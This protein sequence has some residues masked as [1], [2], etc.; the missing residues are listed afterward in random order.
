MSI[1]SILRKY[2]GYDIIEL[3]SRGN[4][5]IFAALYVARKLALDKKNVLIPDQ[6]GWFTYK[7][8]PKKLGLE[9]IEVKTDLGLLDPKDLA[10][11]DANCLLYENPAG[12]YANQ[13]IEKIYNACKCTVILDVSGS[14]GDP[15]LCNG[16]YADIIVGSFGKWKVATAEYGGFVAIKD[17]ETYDIAKEIFN[18]TEFDEA[19]TDDV[20]KALQQVPDRLKF[21]YDEC[22]TIKKDL[23]GM[24]IVYPDKKGI[25]VI[26]RYTTE[27]DKNKILDYCERHKYQWTQCPRYIK[28]MENAISIEVKRR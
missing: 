14:I 27:E 24:N 11:T 18:T 1:K 26:V 17:Q 9:V 19:K 22:N 8:Y 2:T 21:L 12:Y 16:K 7:K 20:Y 15:V 28:I 3:T 13:P 6:G 5:A 10:D 23:S 25:N 4:T